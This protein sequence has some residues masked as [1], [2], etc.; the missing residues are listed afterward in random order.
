MP[1]LDKITFISQ[2]F[3]LLII[4]FS[5]YFIMFK[6]FIP[7]IGLIFKTRSKKIEKNLKQKEFFKNQEFKTSLQYELIIINFL[8]NIEI[9]KK[10][11]INSTWL[12]Q[13]INKVSV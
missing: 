2:V 7:Y 9:L 5:F 12:N 8:K 11:Q 13:N 6:N 3:W 10:L 1:Q 4:F